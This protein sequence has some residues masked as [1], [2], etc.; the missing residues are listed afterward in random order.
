[1]SLLFQSG[2]SAISLFELA[3]QIGASIQA[4]FPRSLWV[5][6]EI[7]EID[8]KRNG[9]CY[10][11]LI[12]RND[13][14]IQAQ[15]RGTIWAFQYKRISRAFKTATG[16]DLVPG[17]KI[18]FACDVSFHERWGLS[19]NIQD[20]DA[21]YT[22]GEMARRRKE[23][24][25]QLKAEGLL[26]LNKQVPFSLVLQRIAIIS[27]ETA[28]GYRDFMHELQANRYG[29]LFV[30][31]LFQ[32]TMQGELTEGSVIRALENISSYKDDVDVV[33]IIRGGGSAVDLSAFDSYAI[34]KAIAL[35]PLPVI[36][37]IGH[38]E[39]ETV[40][41][42]AA[43]LSCKTPTKAAESLMN[44]LRTFENTVEQ[45]SRNVSL[46]C[47]RRLESE[48]QALVISMQK[49]QM[50]VLDYLT[51]HR[52]AEATATARLKAATIRL[53][54]L[55][56]QSLERMRTRLTDSTVSL[57]EKCWHDIRRCE[58]AVRLLDPINILQRGFSITYMDGHAVRE[59][60]GLKR[61][62]EI[63]T[64]LYR[65]FISSRV[66]TVE[67]HNEQ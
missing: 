62:Q 58:Q 4:A 25:A 5:I 8:I 52:Y 13:D 34:G 16:S 44:A 59:A 63:T 19:L 47:Q 3:R 53:L 40:A 55:K 15:M 33:V 37:G 20:I 48:R 64:K 12:E 9:H 32:A 7:A 31:K 54:E 2:S 41:D 23:I 21:S 57:L 27:S 24:I 42:L 46:T 28:A 10:L 50:R 56:L 17:M 51:E 67:E 18:L 39:D 30:T 65:G 35:C 1:M 43:H 61:G 14:G 45:L 6:A 11:T 36:T 60:S 26:E 22:L 66:E 29:Y 49:L 38:E